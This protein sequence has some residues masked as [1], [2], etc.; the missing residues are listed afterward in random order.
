M[1]YEPKFTV[2]SHL[3]RTIE[4]ISKYREIIASASIQVPWIPFLQKDAQIKNTH[5]S[6]AI[7]GNP[8]SIEEVAIL[9]G[10]GDLPV[11]TSRSKKEVLN[12]F[13][14]LRFVE[15]NA[16]KKKITNADLLALH[17]IISDGVMDQGCAGEYRRIDVYV[18]YYQPPKFMK[19]FQ[20]MKDLLM[21]WNNKSFEWSPVIS[22]AIV[23]YRFEAIHPFADGNGR[24]GRLLA[25]W[26]L[27]RRG[28]DT[29]HIFALDEVYWENRQQY[30]KALDQVERN[31][32]DLTGWLEYAAEAL[33]LTLE[34]VLRRI[35]QLGL[36]T[37]DESLVLS[38]KQEILLGLL[39]E[40][41]A[42]KPSE[43]WAA[44]N[45]S[46]QGALNLIKPLMTAGLIKRIGTRKSGKYMLM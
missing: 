21:W 20:L 27:Y 29:N 16:L 26:E 3:L 25:L 38:Q 5:G 17:K 43:I 7:E 30:Y 2:T 34:N 22:S 24:T 36:S 15:K 42:M 19:I 46:K 35:N 18:E 23:H 11:R 33:H 4:D 28:F 44:L 32:S 31:K 12:Y 8:L 39:Q 6:T 13:D 10:G 1:A 9:E 14:A 40:R 41:K 37:C 45:I